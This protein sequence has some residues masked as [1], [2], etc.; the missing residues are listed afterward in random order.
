MR[1]GLTLHV[2]YADLKPKYQNPD[3]VIFFLSG[4]VPAL[5]V[6]TSEWV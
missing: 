1:F 3:Q 4:L 6:E 2:N 5:L